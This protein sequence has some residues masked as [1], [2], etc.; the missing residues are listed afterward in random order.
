MATPEA[1]FVHRQMAIPG[2][3]LEVSCTGIPDVHVTVSCMKIP[4]LR[5][6]VSWKETLMVPLLRQQGRM[7]IDHWAAGVEA[8][9]R[10]PAEGDM[11]EKEAEAA[12]F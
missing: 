2:V 3:Q 8:L 9:D 11:P 10:V 1:Q 6:A 12:R 4:G 7:S 5:L